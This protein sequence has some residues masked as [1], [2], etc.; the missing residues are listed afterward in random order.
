LRNPVISE[1]ITSK[2]IDI[3]FSIDKSLEDLAK[4]RIRK[5]TSSQQ[6]SLTGANDLANLLDNALQSMQMM[7]EARD[8]EK[9]K[10]CLC[11]EKV[12]ER[13]NFNY[14]TLFKDRKN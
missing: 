13:V 10:V 11:L 1:Q 12:V 4:F 5:G 3:D 8:P 14:L 7:M 9:E 2:L 6:Y